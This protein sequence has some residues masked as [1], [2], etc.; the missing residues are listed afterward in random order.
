MRFEASN[1]ERLDEIQK[2]FEGLV[3]SLI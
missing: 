3:D 1:L 2:E